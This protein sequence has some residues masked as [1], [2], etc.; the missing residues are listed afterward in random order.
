MPH[1]RC[2]RHVA[3]LLAA[4][5]VAGVASDVAAQEWR[6]RVRGSWV[7]DGQP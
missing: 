7:R 2:T 3:M 5:L 1:E 4:M 6:G